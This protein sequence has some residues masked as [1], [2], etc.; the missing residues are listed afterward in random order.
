MSVSGSIRA[1][2][3]PSGATGMNS[4]TNESQACIPPVPQLLPKELPRPRERVYSAAASLTLG[5]ICAACLPFLLFAIAIF[6]DL[7][8]VGP[9][10]LVFPFAG[11]LVLLTL[12]FIGLI[13][14][15]RSL[16]SASPP[17]PAAIAATAIN[18]LDVLVL[19]GS[20]IYCLNA[21]THL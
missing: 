2:N 6:R 21:L 1:I 15:F 12:G 9:I 19:L 11:C 14:G 8:H 20:A 18:V 4:E 3:S 5:L 7:R 16:K 10:A 17:R 13:L